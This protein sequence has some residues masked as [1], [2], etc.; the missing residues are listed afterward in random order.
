MSYQTHI[1][2]TVFNPEQA[3]GGRFEPPP[4]VVFFVLVFLF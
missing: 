2:F 4:H 1:D 3:G